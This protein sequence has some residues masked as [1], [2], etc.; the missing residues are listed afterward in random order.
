[1]ILHR[2]QHKSLNYQKYY[3]KNQL[4]LLHLPQVCLLM[5]Q[6]HLLRHLH[7]LLSVLELLYYLHLDFLE[8]GLRVEYFLIQLILHY[9]IHFPHHLILQN[10]HI[11]YFLLH[12]NHLQCL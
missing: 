4:L 3:L 6:Q 12:H 8:M 9:N 1:M 11:H 10:L 7:H 5:F 2:H